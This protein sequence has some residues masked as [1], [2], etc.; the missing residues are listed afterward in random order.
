MK[1][2][3]TGIFAALAMFAAQAGAAQP[4]TVIAIAKVKPGTEA[5]FQAAASKILA[6]TRAESGNLQ[7]NLHQAVAAKGEFAFVEQWKSPEDLDQHLQTP[8]MQAFFAEVK[9]LFEPGYPTITQYLK[10][11][12]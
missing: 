3:I 7:F 2:K 9:D 1:S 8:H 5:A 12:E 4:I 11:E 10:V 6:P